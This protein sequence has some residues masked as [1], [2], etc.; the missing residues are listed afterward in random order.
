MSL[1]LVDIGLN[2]THRRFDADREAVLERA[3]A[4][5]VQQMVLTGTCARSS[6]E[7]SEYAALHPGVLYNTVG[8]HPHDT[9]RATSQDVQTLREL[10]QRP[11]VVAIGE[12]GLDFNR[13]FS[14]RDVPQR[15]FAEQVKLACEL[16]MPLFLHEREAQAALLAV[17]DSFGAQL[18]PVVVH[19]F[20]GSEAEL[21]V[22]L[23]RG[24]FIGITGWICDE[25]RGQHLLEIVSQIPLSRL[26]LETDAPFLT[27][28][29]LRP[30]PK[31]G[32]NEPAFLPHI[33]QTV[34]RAYG[35]SAEEVAT[36]TTATAK[37]FFKL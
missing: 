4:S 10:A 11:E 16:Q 9:E 21:Q 12:C 35:L 14:P 19:C 2:L 6:R 33:L 29:D 23:E 18:P 5:G 37:A 8:I 24:Y 17:L 22:Y 34:A 28:R 32:R 26:M 36:A 15:V 1:A 3:L 31:S 25:R 27:P 7:A 13:D 20:T 30:K